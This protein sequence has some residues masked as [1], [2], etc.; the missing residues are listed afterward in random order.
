MEHV[1]VDELPPLSVEGGEDAD[2]EGDLGRY[3]EGDPD[4]HV[5]FGLIINCVVIYFATSWY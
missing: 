2:L 5:F 3:I 1:L 4:L